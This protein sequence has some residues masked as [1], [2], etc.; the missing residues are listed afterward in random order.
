MEIVQV[1]KLDGVLTAT[2]EN[3]FHLCTVAAKEIQTTF[4]TRR[5]VNLC[6]S[7]K[8]TLIKVLAA[9]KF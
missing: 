3:V 5:S 1:S 6:A 2:K 4:S 9:N 7:G 8:V